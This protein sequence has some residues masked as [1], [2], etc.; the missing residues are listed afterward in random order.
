VAS[1]ISDWELGCEEPPLLQPNGRL[2]HDIVG[3]RPLTHGE[4]AEAERANELLSWLV[5]SPRDSAAKAI[6][7]FFAGVAEAMDALITRSGKRPDPSLQERF[8]TALNQ[9]KRFLDR[10]PKAL[11]KH[12]GDASGADTAFTAACR[13]EYDSSFDYR[14]AY[15]LRNETEHSQDVLTVNF[16]VL[17]LPN[18]KVDRQV[19]TTVSDDVLDAAL[20]STR[21]QASVR[22]E[23]RSRPRPI[24]GDSILKRL[25]TS[26][27]TAFNQALLSQ[28]TAIQ[29]AVARIR[30]LADEAACQGR[31][32]LLR[33][34][35]I[36]AGQPSGRATLDIHTL[37]IDAAR[38]M[39]DLLRS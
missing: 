21:W 13:T 9:Y 18:G 3:L 33:Y 22:R 15:N 6:D 7:E 5:N 32:S 29:G 25:H 36:D 30:A 8:G 4:L 37:Q 31:P 14:L 23:L 26:I 20:D 38:A 16:S 39:A 10:T 24:R 17:V 28:R 1:E 27:D 34:R 11:R 19:S 35:P 12:F 2:Q